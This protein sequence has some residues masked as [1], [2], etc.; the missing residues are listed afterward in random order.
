MDKVMDHSKYQKS[1]KSLSVRQ[2]QFIMKDAKEAMNAN[3]KNPNNGFYA[4]EV[5]YA[6]MELRR[7][8]TSD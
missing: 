5:C 7:R 4:D 1:L 3:P 6:G 2:L 8:T